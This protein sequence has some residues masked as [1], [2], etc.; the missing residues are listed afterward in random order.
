MPKE[1]FKR[2]SLQDVWWKHKTVFFHSH[3]ILM[4]SISK[5]HTNAPLKRLII[6]K[7]TWLFCYI[8]V[9]YLLNQIYYR[10]CFNYFH[11]HIRG[12][13]EIHPQRESTTVWRFVL[14]RTRRHFEIGTARPRNKISLCLVLQIIIILSWFLISSSKGWCKF[15]NTVSIILI[16]HYSLHLYLKSAPVTTSLRFFFFVSGHRHWHLCLSYI[17]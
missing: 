12:R 8:A 3:T 1:I 14:D 6:N 15:L 16:T 7:R 13:L 17:T 9:S 2:S 4:F 11:D 10:I 5:S